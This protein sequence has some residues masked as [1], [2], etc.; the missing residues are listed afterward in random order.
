[1]FL[2]QLITFELTFYAVLHLHNYFR[3]RFSCLFL[4]VCMGFE[5]FG[6]QINVSSKTF[7][8]YLSFSSKYL[9][10][11]KYIYIYSTQCGSKTLLMIFFYI[12]L[13]LDNWYLQLAFCCFLL[14]EIQLSWLMFYDCR[15][16]LL[17]S[18]G[19][20]LTLSFERAPFLTQYRTVWVP[21]N[22]FYVMDT[23]VMKKVS[24]A[25][26]WV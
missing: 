1:M 19:A 16:D 21:W 9:L 11:K 6:I 13:Q 22:V 24:G 15:F 12:F 26:Q 17:A 4:M 14:L 23:L 7:Q 20:S 3:T 8:K 25:L 5:P 18:G 2:S 10:R